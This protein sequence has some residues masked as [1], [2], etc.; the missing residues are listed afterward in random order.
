M[1]RPISPLSRENRYRILK[2]LQKAAEAGNVPAR[3]A[4]VRLSLFKEMAANAYPCETANLRSDP[5]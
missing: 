5:A 1:G 4:L 3:E 2:S